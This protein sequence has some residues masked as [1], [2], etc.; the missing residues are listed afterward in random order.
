MSAVGL[1]IRT[2]PRGTWRSNLYEY[3]VLQDW[4]PQVDL[5]SVDVEQARGEIVRRYLQG[6]GPATFD[7]VQWWTGFSKRDTEKALKPLRP[8]ITEV[9]ISGI[10]SGYLML[11][12]DARQ[13]NSYAP[14][15]SPYV[16]LLPSL[17]P[18]IMG[19]RDRRRFLAEE[20]HKK[21]FD[22][23]GN[24]LP[25]V[26]AGGRLVGAWDQSQADGRVIYGLFEPVG[27]AEESLLAARAQRLGEL[28][29]DTFIKPAFFHT[30]FTRHLRHH[31][32]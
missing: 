8:H 32:R 14:E 29:G 26:W 11:Q 28:L 5:R 31:G 25:T 4:L 21:V 2:K 24:A 3:A 15:P 13:L 1:I 16:F 9:D 10:G 18:Y 27:E 7:D 12:D 23:A 6:F 22:R 19:Y 30:P 17:D 20:H